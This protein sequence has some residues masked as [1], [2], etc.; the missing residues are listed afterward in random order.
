[1]GEAACDLL[2]A[3]LALDRLEAELATELPAHLR[4]LARAHADGVATPG[5][6]AVA[7]RP[8]SLAVARAALVHPVL[9]DRALAQ[10]RLLA[11]IAI[12][13]EPSVAAAR[14]ADPTWDALAVLT[15]ARD[16][17]A[18]ARFGIGFLELM[19]RLHGASSSPPP[20]VWPDPV[21]GWHAA[22]EPLG[23]RMVERAWR[24]LAARHGARGTCRIVQSSAESSRARAFVVESGR[25]VI[26]VI[27]R[28][29]DT[30]AARF[31]VL[32]ELG[33]AVAALVA[34]A[35]PRIVDEA[36]AA[37]SARLI[38]LEG[39]LDLGWFTPLAVRARERR[40]QLAIALDAIERD[41]VGAPAR[42]TERPPWALWHDPGAQAAYAG[43]ELIADR[44]WAALGPAPSAGAFAAALSDEHARIDGGTFLPPPR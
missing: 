43:A 34:G 42:P 17:A 3:E 44:W 23:I 8:G 19:H 25:E 21:D 1:M 38:E 20:G 22:D 14:A 10:V 15:V 4:G 7:R 37:Y 13:D 24:D 39:A 35:L 36:A 27:P 6:P 26:V 2:G 28:T 9:A 5:A 33:H 18:R 41:Q 12:E 29:L 32:H 40:R 11:P 31:V 16:T 30:P